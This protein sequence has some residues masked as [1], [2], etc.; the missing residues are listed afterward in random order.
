M[1]IKFQIRLH[2]INKTKYVKQDNEFFKPYSFF[3]SSKVL[4]LNNFLQEK[5]FY[6]ENIQNSAQKSINYLKIFETSADTKSKISNIEKKLKDFNSIKSSNN[7]T[8]DYF[9]NLGVEITE[10]KSKT[11]EVLED[12]RLIIVQLIDENNLAVQNYNK[13]SSLTFISV[14]I[15]QLFIFVFIQLFEISLERRIRNG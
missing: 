11:F 8:K 14:F 4:F 2:S 3:I 7:E 12:E 15:V 10:I 13:L 9:F 5:L 1:K 6:F